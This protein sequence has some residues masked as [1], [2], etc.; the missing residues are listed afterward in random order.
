METAPGTHWIGGWMDLRAGLDTVSKRKIPS[1]RRESNLDH[2][3]FQPVASQYTELSRLMNQKG[4][5]KKT[6]VVFAR[7]YPGIRLDVVRKTMK[8]FSQDSL[9]VNLW[10]VRKVT[11]RLDLRQILWEGMD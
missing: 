11:Q 2:P 10:L 8:I 7:Y 9:F 1:P 5:G 4:Y 3:V 6:V